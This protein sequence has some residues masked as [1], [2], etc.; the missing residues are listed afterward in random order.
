MLRFGA[1][2]CARELILVGFE[3]FGERAEA[4][5]GVFEGSYERFR[6]K[7]RCE[8]VRLEDRNMEL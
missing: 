8:A 3:L 1:A 5:E 4:G 6:V 2:H 7:R